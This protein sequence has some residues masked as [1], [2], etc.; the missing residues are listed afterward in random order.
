MITDHLLEIENFLSRMSIKRQ[1]QMFVSRDNLRDIRTLLL[2]TRPEYKLTPDTLDQL[3]SF[4]VNLDVGSKTDKE[5]CP[6]CALKHL[7]QAM[8]LMT[9]IDRESRWKII[10]H[11]QEAVEQLKLI[12]NE[13]AVELSAE[14]ELMEE[15][16]DYNPTLTRFVNDLEE[17]MIV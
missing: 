17:Y 12:D 13:I 10:G 4:M 8:A 2:K 9:A 1:P 7:G 14:I 11:M 5:K 6:K 3:R 15:N 16:R